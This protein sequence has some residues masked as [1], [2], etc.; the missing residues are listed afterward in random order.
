MDGQTRSEQ[1][2]APSRP[3]L[4]LLVAAMTAVAATGSYA[5]R[6]Q[7][8]ASPTTLP[9]WLLAVGFAASVLLVV[10]IPTSRERHSVTL[11]V[12]P[13]VLSLFFLT[14]IAMIGAQVVGMT[15]ALAGPLRV[16]GVK[17]LFNIAQVALQAVIAVLVFRAGA[18][19]W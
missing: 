11:S 18:G 3:A 17:L 7:P 12:I 10:D 2:H 15:T 4:P 1:T 5:L 8:V 16:R 9:V 14:P 13:I 6:S 19:A